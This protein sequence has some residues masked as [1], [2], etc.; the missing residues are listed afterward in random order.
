VVEP[1]IPGTTSGA[2]AGSR[3][4]NIESYTSSGSPNCSWSIALNF[5][6]SGLAA[7]ST[8]E[9]STGGAAAWSSIAATASGATGGDPDDEVGARAPRERLHVV[10]LPASANELPSPARAIRVAARS[11]FGVRATTTAS[12]SRLRD[13]ARAARRSTTASRL[14][15]DGGGAPRSLAVPESAIQLP[16]W[17]ATAS[18]SA[19]AKNR[20]RSACSRSRMVSNCQW[21]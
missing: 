1:G 19:A 10:A 11:S 6:A 17:C 4:L 21:K 2:A 7:E 3:S 13:D 5:S 9:L 15:T 8:A 14:R 16:S 12:A 18:A 20:L